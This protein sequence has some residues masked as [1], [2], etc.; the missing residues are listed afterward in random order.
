MLISQKKNIFRQVLSW[1]VLHGSLLHKL[2]KHGNLLNIDISQGSVAACF[3]YGGTLKY[4]SCKFTT[5]FDSERILK[6]G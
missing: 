1:W 3:R 6:I 2:R 5:E 4:D